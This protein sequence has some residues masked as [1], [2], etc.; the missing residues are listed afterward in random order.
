VF[1]EPVDEGVD[2][3]MVVTTMVLPLETERNV[4]GDSEGVGVSLGGGVEE[5]ED[6][7]EEREEEDVEDGGGAEVGEVELRLEV[8]T[9]KDVELSSEVLFGGGGGGEGV[10]VFSPGVDTGFELQGCHHMSIFYNCCDTGCR[11]LTVGVG[12]QTMMCWRSLDF[13]SKK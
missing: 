10:D 12:E 5:G 8:D 2:R 1:T 13:R 11:A 7:D 4:D 9:G 6:G 3:I